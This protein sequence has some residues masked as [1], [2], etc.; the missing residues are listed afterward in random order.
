[1]IQ[2]LQRDCVPK[3]GRAQYIGLQISKAL[4]SIRAGYECGTADVFVHNAYKNALCETRTGR[5][6]GVRFGGRR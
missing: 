2:A 5:P 4:E 6:P 1:M 3:R